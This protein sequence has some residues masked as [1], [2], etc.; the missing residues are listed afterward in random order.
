MSPFFLAG[1][2]N[3]NKRTKY[4][5]AHLNLDTKSFIQ[6][7]HSPVQSRRG[8]RFQ[9]HRLRYDW[10]APVPELQT[11]L[12]HGLSA[13]PEATIPKRKKPAN[14]WAHPF[15]STTTTTVEVICWVARV[16][17]E[18]RCGF[19]GT[20]TPPWQRHSSSRRPRTVA[21]GRLV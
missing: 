21:R 7:P 3:K 18:V 10:L 16:R 1:I 19:V 5:R 13:L 12:I 4:T 14:A 9:L 8:A 6:I 17:A 11:P 20:P 2:Q 15:E